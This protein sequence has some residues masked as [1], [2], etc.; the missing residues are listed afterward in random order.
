M[1]NLEIEIKAYC[2]DRDGIIKKIIA[3]G[4]AYIKT[5][6]ETDF[7]FNHPSRNFAETDEA[8]R[9]RL[10]DDAVFITYKGP[11]IGERSKTRTEE[12]LAVS[13]F[14]A[15]RAILDHLGFRESGTVKK[16]RQYFSLGG[17]TLC[18][19]T[20]E[21]LG[22]FIELEI[23]GTDRE[24]AENDLFTLAGDLGLNRFERRSYLELL[25]F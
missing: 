7:Y 21:G 9:I 5:S 18:L 20:V 13:D 12:E 3:L 8:F 19:D 11:K 17:M 24:K 15:M 14:D 2:D 6:V 23:I 22:N 16:T 4:G 25:Y 1:R 10:G